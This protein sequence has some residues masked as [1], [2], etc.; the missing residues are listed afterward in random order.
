M[1][2]PPERLAA[3]FKTLG[4][5]KRLKII[6][7]LNNQERNVGELAALL[8]LTEPTVSHH[9]SRLREMGLVNLRQVG[10]Q[11]RY[12]LNDDMLK[13]WKQAVMTVE[14][15]NFDRERS[16]S[17]DGW[18]DELD[19]DEA[20][21]KVLRDYTFNGRLKHVPAKRKKLL[22]VLRWLAAQ[23]ESDALYTER[24]VNV[25]LTRY[26]EDY[27]ALRRDLVDFKFLRRERDG[28]TYWKA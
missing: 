7:L 9:L 14:A 27:A 21:R 28:A 25:I 13:R 20:D 19:V 6:N 23:F 22:V 11:R 24:E 10:N 3:F 8:D 18:I 17:D 2:I 12:R 1:S 16:E 5:E 4:D 15:M 26:H